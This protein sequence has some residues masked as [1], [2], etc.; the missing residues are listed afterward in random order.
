MCHII[1]MRRLPIVLVVLVAVHL[2]L[3]SQ[4]AEPWIPSVCFRR[5]SERPLPRVV[6][7]IVA[8]RMS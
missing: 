6:L 4:A 2:L 1:V 3:A 7:S 8:M 5:G